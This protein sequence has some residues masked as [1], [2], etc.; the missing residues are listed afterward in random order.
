VGKAGRDTVGAPA[1]DPKLTS[2]EFNNV[3]EKAAFQR[4]SESFFRP[5]QVLPVSH[6]EG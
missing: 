4:Q 3:G 2:V 1:Y 5:W 6:V